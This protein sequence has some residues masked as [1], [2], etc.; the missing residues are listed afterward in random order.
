[1]RNCFKKLILP[2]VL[3]MFCPLIFSGCGGEEQTEQP[4]SSAATAS[5][6]PSAAPST[7][8][9]EKKVVSDLIVKGEANNEMSYDL[10]ITGPGMSLEGKVWFKDIKMKIDVVSNGKRTVSIFNLEKGEVLTY[11]PGE[12]MA[13]KVKVE[14]YPGR[15]NI[16]PV[17]YVRLLDETAYKITGSE[18]IDGMECKVITTALEQGTVKQWLSNEYGIPVQVQE[19][20]DGQMFT[21]EFQN[22]KIASVPDSTFELPEGVQILDLNNIMNNINGNPDKINEQ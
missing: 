19:E 5:V 2:V 12:D 8:E 10:V 14:E 22:I 16:T 4:S 6:S 20:L 15:D 3:L 18:N 21:Y 7:S 17:D 11:I 1:M 13:T 9:D